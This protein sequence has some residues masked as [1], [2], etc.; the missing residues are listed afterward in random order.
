MEHTD[1]KRDRTALSDYIRVLYRHP[2]LPVQEEERL[3]GMIQAGD[4]AALDKLVRHNLRFVISVVKDMP[5]WQNGSVPFEDIVAIGNESLL[6]AA[7]KWVPR[8][9]ARFATYAKPFI[10]KGIRRTLDNEWSMIRV[11]VNILE[12]I[13]RMKYL[14]RVLSQ[15]LRR[16]PTQAE[17][18]NRMKVHESRIVELQN[19]LTLEP[20]S[21][22]A[23]NQEKFH[24]ESEE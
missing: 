20:V 19:L 22:E 14:E 21:L 6:K 1:L 12:E 8:N 9:G 11:P 23:Y 10:V 24:E 4:N 15:E 3:S 17:L 5:I 2:V 13:R 16:E 7:R 18:A